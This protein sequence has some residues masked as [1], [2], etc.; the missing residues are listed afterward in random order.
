MT[1]ADSEADL[2][3][4][5]TAPRAVGAG[6]DTVTVAAEVD[7][8]A[9]PSGG[10]DGRGHA[11]TVEALAAQLGVGVDALWRGAWAITLARLA[12]VERVRIAREAGDGWAAVVVTV[13]AEGALSW[14]AED[15][16]TPASEPAHS[17][18]ST[19]P[20]TDDGPALLWQ[21]TPTGAQARFAA[22]RI[23]RAAVE[24]LA[25]AL[26]AV[27]AGLAAPDARLETV[28]PLTAD[29]RDRVVVQWNQTRTE[30]RTEATVHGL[31]REQ[32]AAHPDAVA[33]IWDGGSL[34]YGQLDRWSDALAERLIAAGVE[35]DQPVALC[36]ER[37][38]EAVVAALAILKAGGAY[39]P[40]DPDHP[41][42]RLAF[43]VDDAGATV[44]VTRRARAATLAALAART[45]FVDDDTSPAHAASPRAERATPHTR[46]Y[47]MYTSGSTGQPKGVQI[48]HRSIV[49]LVGR[50]AYV[51]LDADTRFLHAAPLG[52]DA[53]TLELWGP[54]LHGGSVVIYRDPVPTGRGLARAIAAHGV[55]SAW[56][57]SALFNAVVDEDPRLLSGLAQL[58]TGGE[59]LSPSHVRRALAALPTTELVNGYGPTECTTFTTTFVIPRDLPAEL[60]I[61]IGGPIADT[62]IYVLNRA[63]APVPV[64][65]VGE[66]YVG[67]LGVA[68]GYLAR[69][70]L[71]A[72]RFVADHL[73]AGLL[74]DKL[75]R[76]GDRVR[77]RPDGTIDFLG[78]ADGQVK[79]RGFR[80]E[81]G[82]IEA[83]LGALPGVAACAVVIRDDGPTGK[84]LV[85]YVVAGADGDIGDIGAPALRGQLART[86]PEFMVPAAF[87]ALAALPVTAN[88]KLDRKQLPAPTSARPELGQPYRAPSS[89]RETQLCRA[90]AELL[91]ID[92]VGVLDGFFDLGGNSLLAVKLLGRL[93]D[94]GIADLSPAI[95]FAAPTPAA[96]AR[97]ID[98]GGRTPGARRRATG[99]LREPIAII[100]MAGRFPG[101]ADVE[102]FWANLCAGT[103]SIK[104]FA[105]DELDPSIPAAHRGDPSYVAARGVLDGVEL[106][107]AGFFGITPLEAQLLDPQ[108]RHFL[109]VSW[110]ALEHAGYVPETAPGPV[111]IFGGMYN[112]TYFQRHLAPRPDVANRLGE[113]AVMLGNEKDYVTS[114][115]AHRLGLTGPAVSVHTACS[116]SLVATAMAMDSL[117]NGGCDVALAGG[118]AITCPPS[119]GY[120]FQD[121][122]MA[123]PDGHTR[124]FDAQAGGTVFSDGVAVVVL[125]RLA[126]AIADGDAIYAVLLGAAV[127]NDGSERAS[128]TAP[129]PEGQAAV[130]AAAHDAAGID[131]RSLSY[132]EAHGTATP[133]GDPIEIEGLTRA[134]GRHTQDRNFCA[135]GSLKSNVGHMV[136]AAGAASLIKTALALSRRTLPPSINFTAPTPKIDFSKTPFRVQTQLAPWPE[137]LGPRRAG[138]SSFGFGGTNAHAVLEEAPPPVRSTPSPRGAELIV[139]S[140]RNAA[141]L[142]EASTNLARFLAAAPEDGELADVA[143]TLQ[144]GRRGFTHRRFVV[145]STAAE[146]ARL[147]AAPEPARAGSREVGAELPDVGFLC[148][149][150]GSQYARMGFGLYHHEPAFRAAYDECC[151]ILESIDGTPWGGDPRALLF[152]EDPQA[153]VPTS[154]TQ[155][156]IFALEYALARMWMSWGVTPSALIGHSVGEWVCAALADVM[157][158]R[159]ALGLVVERGRRMQALPAGS[160]L[161]VRLPAEQLAPRLPAG[162]VIAAEN[163]PGLCVASGP[164]DAIARLE[165]EL[166][167]A[168]VTARL[169]VTS[170]AFHSAMMDPVIEPL[171]ARLATVRLQAP[172]IPILSTVTARWLSD[173]EAT[174]T[175]YWAE[176]LRLPVRFAPAVAQLLTESRRVLIEIGP[177]A[178]LSALARQ[179]VVGKRALPPAIPTLADSA[180]REPEAAAAALGQL[181]TLGASID[182]AGYRGDER[183]RRVALPAYPFQR[184]RH[185]VDAP[186]A[187]APAA[188]L[189]PPPLVAPIASLPAHAAPVVTPLVAPL[190]VPT[191][192]MP[193]AM[194]TAPAADRRPRMIASV[195]ELVEEVSGIDVTGVDPSTPWLEIGL[196]S[197]TLTQLALQVQ[198]THQLKVTFR[199]VM[200]SYP[201]IA[202]L[203]QMLDE[204]LPAD[205]AAAPPAAPAPVA[206]PAYPAVTYAAAAGEPSSYLRQVIDQQL[207]VMAQQ[208]AALGGGG[209]LPAAAP[210]AA[211][212]PVAAAPRPSAAPLPPP[213]APVA[214]NEDEPPAGPV[215]Y[216]VKKAFGA[217]ARIHTVVD[218]LSPQQRQRLDALIARYTARTRKSKDYTTTH[219]SR[220]ADP[221]VVNGFRPLTKELTYQLV[222]ERSRGSRMWDLDGNEYIDVLSGFGMSLFGWQ[223]D[224]IR[225]A[226]HEQVD[227]GFEIGPQHVLAG[228][229]AELF[230]DVT[231]ADRAAFCNTGSEAVMGTM[232]IARTVT[233]RSTIAIFTGAYHGIFD[234]V[235]VRGTRK[236]KSIPAAPGI[237]P[238][239]S[240]NVLVLD[241]G[242][243]ESL[244]ILRDRADELAAIVVEPVQSRR[245][246]FQ[247][248]AFLRELRALTEATGSLLIFDEV[249]TGF[250]AHPRGAQGLF[251]IQADLASYGKVVGGGFSIGVIAGKRQFMDALDGG[252]WQFGDDSIP[253]VGV[254]YFAGTFVRHPLALA[255]AK[256]ALQHLKDAGPAL[257][258][259]LTA[260]TQAMVAE[261]NAFMAEVG[262]PF[263][264]NT[265]ASLWRNVFTEDLPYGDLIYAMLRDR[266]IHILDN[267]PCFL[268]TAHSDAD[269]AAI[270]AAYKAAA[271][272]MQASGFFPAARTAV[273][274]VTDGVREAP[275]TEPQREVWL[276]ASLGPEASLAYNESVSLHLRGELDVAALRLAV[277]ALPARHDALRATFGADGLTV[278]AAAAPEVAE[279]DVPLRDLGG[280]AP[281]ARDEEL[282]AITARHVTEPF[283]LEH[284]PLI[285]AEL[286][287]LTPDH[288]VLVFTGHHIVLDGWSYWV[289]VKDL[290]ATYG[291]ATGS[292][293]AAL[294]PAPSFLDYATAQ[295]ARAD[296]PD[297]QTNE[298]WWIAQFA[299]GVPALDLP[300]DRPRPAMRTTTAGR[301]DHVLPAA[302]VAQIKKTGAALGASLFA[303]LLAGFDALLYRLTGQTDLVVGIPAAGQNTDGLEG[304]VG[305]AVN[306]LPLRARLA[307]T[308]RFADHVSRARATMLDAYDHQDVTFG[309]VLQV[310]PIARDASRLPLIS[311]IFNID[312]A[313]SGEALSLPGVAMALSSNARVHETFELFIN[314]VDGGAAGMRLEC[315]YNSDLFDAGTVRRWLAAFE[316][317]LRGAVA[318]PALPL[319]KLPIVSEADRALL[320]RW[321]RTEADFPRAT[322]VE[323]LILATAQRTPDRIAVRAR[324]G[325]L[326]YGQLATRARAITAELRAPGVRPGDRVG[327]LVD[328]DLDLLP[329]IVGTLA[330]GAAYVPLDP[331]FP[332]DRLRFMVE[333]AGLVAILT[334]SALAASAATVIGAVPAVML[335]DVPPHA[336]PVSSAAIGLP[337]I[338]DNTADAAAYVIY[339]SGS[340]GKP[341]GVCVPHRAV[342][343]FLTSIAREPGMTERDVVLAVTTLS[344]DIAVLELLLPLAVGGEIILATRDEATDGTALAGLLAQHRATVM[345]ATP[346]TWRMLIE[347]GWRGAPTLT[348][349]CGGEALPRDLAVELAARVGRLWNMYGPTETTVWSTVHRIDDPDGPILIGH[350]IANTKVHV[351]DEDQQPVPVGVV[352][353]LYIGGDGV[354]LG[355]HHRPELTAEKFVADRSRLEPHA[356]MYR[357]GDLGRWRAG[358]DGSGAIECLGRTDFQ[359]KVRGYRIELGEIEVALARHPAVTQ[360]SVI[361]RE[362][363]PG[364]VRLVAYVVPRTGASMPSDETLRA[365][366][367]HTLP[368]YMIPARF[369]ALAALPLTG[370]GKVDRKALPVPTGPA[371]AGQGTL[372]APRT[373]TEHIVA[374]AYQETLAVP[375][376]SVYDDFFALGGHSLLVAQ[377]TARLSRTLARSVPM[378]AGFE[379]ATVASLAAWLDG[380]AERRAGHDAPPEHIARRAETTPAPLSLMQQ[381]VWY[382]E[383]LQLG[384]TVFNVPS[385]HRL[386]GPLDVAALGRA[387]TVLCRRQPILRTAIGT[388]G[389][390]P[391]QL[392]SDE[393]DTSIAVE[394]LSKLGSDAREAQLAKRLELEIAQPFE[395]TRAPLFR[396]RLYRLA[397]EEHVL[398]FMAHH[399]IWDGWSFDVFYEEMAALYAAELAGVPSDRPLPPVTYA[400]FTVWHRAWLAGPELARQIEHWRGKLAGAPDALDLPTDHPRPPIQSGDGA[401]EWLSLPAPTAAALRTVGLREGATLFMTLLSAWTA[402]LHQ[403]TRQPEII[404]GTPVRGRNLPELEQVMGFFVNALP[405]RLRVDPDTSFLELLR[406]VRRETVEAFGAHDV[407]FEHLVRVLDT[408]RDESRFPIYQAFFSYQDARARPPR[409]GNVDHQNVPVF[410]PSAA[411]DV[412]LWFLDGADGLV[413][414]LNYSTDIIAPATAGRWRQRDL[415]LVEAIAADPDRPIRQLLEVTGEERAQLAAW[416]RTERPLAADATLNALLAPLATHGD[417]VAI[418]HATGDVTYAQL[419]DQR[420]RVAAALAA[421]GVRRGDVV[422]LLLER[423]PA[424][425]AALLGTLAAGATYVPLDP[426]FPASRLAFML[427]DAGAKVVITDLEATDPEAPLAALNLD[428]AHLLRLTGL[429][430]APAAQVAVGPDDAA[431]LIYTS[432]STGR[433]KGVRV[434]QRAVANFLI[435]MREQPGLHAGDRLVA[436]TTLSF[437]IAVLELLLPLTVGAEIVLATRE[438]ATDGV[439]LRG[440]IE[441]HKATIMQATPAT[442]RMLIEA[443]WRGGA[444]FTALCGGEALPPELAEALLHRVG[445]LWNMYGP[446]ETTVWSTCAR[447]EL[448]SGGVTIGTPIANTTA[449]ILDDAGAPVPIGVPGE[450]YLGGAGVALGY[451][452]RPELTAEKFVVDRLSSGHGG[453]GRLYRTG[454]LARW[455]ADG[456]LQHLGRTDFQVKVRGY[457]IELGEIEVALTRHAQIGEAVVVAQPGPGGEQ[458]LVAYVVARG[459]APSAG[460]LREHLRAS[461]PDYMVPAVFVPLE[462]LPLTPNGKVD[463]RALPAP[464]VQAPAASEVAF[465]GPRTPG[466]LLVAAVWRELLHVE[467]IAVSDNFLDLGGHSLLIMQAIAKLEARTGKRIS[468]RTFIFQTLEQIARDYDTQRPEPPKPV[469]PPVAPPPTSRLQRWLSALI[470]KS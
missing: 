122:S 372:V 131:A 23:E 185:W 157:S 371:V 205:P 460:E 397:P 21:V 63:A 180:E 109:E 470:P 74:G 227:L 99:D 368:D 249:V 158:L 100:G 297:V 311:V 48:E 43:S 281:A 404:V 217:I 385:A 56:L 342:V 241:Y 143:H 239:A 270:V 150:Q 388:V 12:G 454:D 1:R 282:A 59:A 380:A 40:L 291:L 193:A 421:R 119:S 260:K 45:V 456:Q 57:T 39:L 430:P 203:A 35:A 64:G 264:L 351:L 135:I 179:A 305:H 262:A 50:P 326:T 124:T 13:P 138:V 94:A 233:G 55:T 197:L 172:R 266:G 392:V 398:F 350:P 10:A 364:D 199:Q 168:D 108:H 323:E 248:V 125:R 450:L 159:D 95:F 318:D 141:A 60:P 386:R 273:A 307:R 93:R 449:W 6:E 463:R 177:R 213:P 214:K 268:T 220:M 24:R 211:P 325:T 202:S 384:R 410:Q 310:L 376:L 447:V 165:A 112:A 417:R 133:L 115:V 315:Q 437:D 336:E 469:K 459:A 256:A 4:V 129:S 170:H 42:D 303:T 446:T 196:D 457:R 246:D 20:L 254:T 272:E 377:M 370:S 209:A 250:R 178:T 429:P 189:A 341:K 313:L 9:R 274:A 186:A 366:L 317:L 395:L 218:E 223:A 166:T 391:A 425:L 361:T 136:I 279:L 365:H 427:A 321:N 358:T 426:G 175:R 30:Y 309:R 207:A 232:R 140:A 33:L 61:P 5:V 195:C 300:T 299:D 405:L 275:S 407:P 400:D 78:R 161:S 194:T 244:Q 81:L 277:R 293:S 190:T 236:L 360:A 144:I 265:F 423:T 132:V 230:C 418:R 408:K 292:R 98:G 49:R 145:A 52:F 422:A 401:T 406:R 441:S 146:A 289:I 339:T 374:A 259:R 219:R 394:D 25:D 29:E 58:F 155:P 215:N 343:N 298:R 67:G 356:R 261:V 340:T 68:R 284:G 113:L 359:V 320:T 235:I 462:R 65:I 382:L 92:Q 353:E 71:D 116:T 90:F 428:A 17:A 348:A 37:S 216:D 381:R 271:T 89:E 34:S 295:A 283:D 403:L 192:E 334:T 22:A 163:A 69:P 453:G 466:E 152:S 14:L 238:S 252:H 328:R 329:A 440:L 31:V 134:F 237:M 387:F 409:W 224:F 399:I 222:I 402:L 53:S 335:D 363:R 149:G 442:W 464:E 16:A 319:G 11:P 162:V 445:V 308:D 390:A 322:R 337:A 419:A 247:P 433:P 97:A 333:D 355:Y 439:A 314:A 431:Y 171:A 167:A 414:G 324:G 8:T 234:E 169:L 106:F 76:T 285:R 415:A 304:L 465:S 75:Y 105:P 432:G 83:R 448:G 278:R 242:T 383:Q 276:A 36:L 18:W 44:L 181:W 251:D 72:E 296:S 147:L 139:V 435:S 458:R 345:Q 255:A 154:V 413:G 66:L 416:N 54:L 231:G 27:I 82:E 327:L 62:Q 46:A 128:F 424:M 331:A 188:T 104:M 3:D 26:A 107:D 51:R 369:V 28:S 182:W 243:P 96:L 411:Q 121:G 184:A 338:G 142:A 41:V 137:S 389:D 114:R 379:H 73:G 127:N 286:V 187:V 102:A 287:R 294:D 212:A 258:Q 316:V 240:Q 79:L 346:A 120:F 204:R 148:P 101:A 375:R 434:P 156:A 229:V 367:A 117:R 330:A 87:V 228:E 352:G 245:P 378:R 452:E 47:V 70:E 160:M 347:T 173:A 420:D 393:L 306:M 123:S 151:S 280:L 467:R 332:T 349:L 91:G 451:H 111:G 174:S 118:V 221:R 200:E 88:G 468:P 80:I 444:A 77:W 443:G 130:I 110:H 198:R 436:V 253:T 2:F 38:A 153:L 226:I 461:L 191:L 412:A 208:L 438:Q 86:L 257:Q 302:L 19:R 225:K 176:H 312:Q 288:H 183:R 7:R 15:A 373:P 263:K 210:V 455:R 32:A 357:T 344:F 290:A 354:T 126:D 84:R 85:A 206:A 267:F 269:I 396:I 103:E 201:T 301:E 164:S 362:D